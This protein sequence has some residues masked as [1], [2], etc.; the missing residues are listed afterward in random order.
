MSGSGDILRA[1]LLCAAVGLAAAGCGTPALTKPL[2][3]PA[4]QPSTDV[5]G[6]PMA[7]LFLTPESEGSGAMSHVEGQVTIV[8]F[9]T[10]TCV[11]CLKLAPELDA[12]VASYPA[13]SVRLVHVLD[14]RVDSEE[15]AAAHPFVHRAVRDPDGALF[16]TLGVTAYPSVFVVDRK[17]LIVWWQATTRAEL[18]E[19]WVTDTLAATQAP[20]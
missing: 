3:G 16:K 18:V 4:L 13:G 8:E 5:I 6:K 12:L 9:G 14:G 19:E 17:G 2:N 20:D 15:E 10:T 1:I 11:G 7:I